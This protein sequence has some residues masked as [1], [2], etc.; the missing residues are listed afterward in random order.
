[1]R[2]YAGKS[3]IVH[4]NNP[5]K[6]KRCEPGGWEKSRAGMPCHSSCSSF[7]SGRRNTSMLLDVGDCLPEIK[8]HNEMKNF[9]VTNQGSKLYIKTRIGHVDQFVLFNL[10]GL[11]PSNAKASRKFLRSTPK[12]PNAASVSM[13]FHA[14]LSTT[15]H[16]TLSELTCLV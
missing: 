4:I 8:M 6:M 9:F 2:P 3:E 7:N 15:D 12:V 16:M 14:G 10:K 13:C 5:R 11:T 1:M